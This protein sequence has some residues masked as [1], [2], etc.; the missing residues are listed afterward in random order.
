[1][2]Y[3]SF[4]Q[5]RTPWVQVILPV[6][7]HH[8]TGGRVGSRFQRRIVLRNIMVAIPV[9]SASPTRE[10]IRQAGSSQH[11]CNGS[12]QSRWHDH[13]RT[14]TPVC[15]RSWKLP[16]CGKSSWSKSS[17]ELHSR[18]GVVLCLPLPSPCRSHQHD[19]WG[20][21][22]ELGDLMP[23]LPFCAPH[24][25]HTLGCARAPREKL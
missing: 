5:N 9:V 20:E 8:R 23:G 17:W 21:V 13:P 22:H 25:A 4:S 24:W 7:A 6:T 14:P 12:V 10:T 11:D 16:R 1:M 15:P 3:S 19:S 18:P 2:F